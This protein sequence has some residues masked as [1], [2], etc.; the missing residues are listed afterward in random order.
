MINTKTIDKSMADCHQYR[1]YRQIFSSIPINTNK[2]NVLN[3]SFGIEST[4]STG[5][6]VIESPIRLC[7]FHILETN[8]P[9]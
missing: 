1:A 2:K 8:T 5:N 4:T 9:L 3:A 6:I 7:E